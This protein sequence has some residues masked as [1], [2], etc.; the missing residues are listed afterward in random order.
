MD[1]GS[2]PRGRDLP[3]SATLCSG[4]HR[5]TFFGFL[6]DDHC[7]FGQGGWSDRVTPRISWQ[8]APDF[9]GCNSRP[10]TGS[11]HPVATKTTAE[12]AKRSELSV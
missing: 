1:A 2:K 12:V 7:L 9:S 5:I 4:M 10:G 3:K 8:K 6:V 11:L